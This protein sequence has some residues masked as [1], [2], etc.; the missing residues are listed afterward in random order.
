MVLVVGS[1]LSVN[2]FFDMH[3]QNSFHSFL[4]KNASIAAAHEF[5]VSDQQQQDERLGSVHVAAQVSMLR[6]AAH[7]SQPLVS[8]EG[9]MDILSTGVLGSSSLAPLPTVCEL[10]LTFCSI[11][12][13]CLPPRHVTLSVVRF[14]VYARN[15][16]SCVSSSERGRT[17]GT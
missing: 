11:M 15:N 16:T 9:V 13:R 14:K 4:F 1:V 7:F 10:M 5:A 17:S 2:L 3:G 6:A 12:Y 8:I